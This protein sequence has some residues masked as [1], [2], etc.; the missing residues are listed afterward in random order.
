MKE[1]IETEKRLK[2]RLRKT[3]FRSN[4][5]GHKITTSGKN[6]KKER[7]IQIAT[8]RKRLSV[9]IFKPQCELSL[10]LNTNVIQKL[11]GCCMCKRYVMLNKIPPQE[12]FDAMSIP[13]TPGELSDLTD[14]KCRL[15]K[16]LLF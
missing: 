11:Y 5:K 16:T 7:L 4:L 6:R 8:R 13:E 15:V 3:H 2:H 12:Q 10:M 9:V 1:S 14:F